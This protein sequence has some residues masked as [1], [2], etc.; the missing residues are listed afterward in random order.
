MLKIGVFILFSMKNKNLSQPLF[1]HFLE[2]L[3]DRENNAGKYFYAV[4][5]IELEKLI[6]E[7]P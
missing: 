5:L 1:I 4:R 6:N 2:N 7:L 3:P